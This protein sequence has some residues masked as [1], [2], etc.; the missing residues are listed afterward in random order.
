M[1]LP[2]KDKYFKE[3]KAGIKSF[4][5]RDAHITFI[6]EKTKETLR[7]EVVSIKIVS[8]RSIKQEYWELFEDNF[9]LRFGL[10]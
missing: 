9:V 4:E 3:I 6:N 7:K 1:K 2:I 5:Y 8:L 10:R